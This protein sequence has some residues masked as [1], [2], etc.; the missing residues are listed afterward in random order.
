[1]PILQSNIGL[2]YHRFA[3]LS[4]ALGIVS[5]GHTAKASAAGHSGSS[6]RKR[7]HAEVEGTDEE[8]IDEELGMFGRSSRSS[9]PWGRRLVSYDDL[10]AEAVLHPVSTL[11]RPRTR[12]T[13]TLRSLLFVA[14][15]Q[16]S[17]MLTKQ[18]SRSV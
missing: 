9:D 6:S 3:G 7:K 18:I 8:R 16:S 14:S 10:N 15:H 4:Q 1:M 17:P 5:A 12:T 2:T 11:P 13:M